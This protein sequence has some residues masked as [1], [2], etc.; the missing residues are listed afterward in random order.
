MNEIW[1]EMPSKHFSIAKKWYYRFA[2]KVKENGSF[3]NGRSAQVD[4]MLKVTIELFCDAVRRAR[5]T[6]EELASARQFLVQLRS[7]N[8]KWMF[9]RYVALF[10]DCSLL[11][12]NN[13]SLTNYLITND[14]KT[15]KRT[16]KV[17]NR[18]LCACY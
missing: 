14:W 8:N 9:V 10:A 4:E 15:S 12:I 18:N 1:A 16:V 13:G 3:L 11:H 17:F 5:G 6:G 7:V 2:K